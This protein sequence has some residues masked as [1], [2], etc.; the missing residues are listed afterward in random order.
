MTTPNLRF[1][2]TEKAA[3]NVSK[4]LTAAGFGDHQALLPSKF[5]TKKKAAGPA[6][7]EGE[8]PEGQEAGESS[9]A[10]AEEAVKA[11]VAAGMLPKE[12]AST[13]VDKLLED[14]SAVA[15]K[16]PYGRSEEA[17]EILA[18]TGVVHDVAFC[19]PSHTPALFSDSFGMPVLSESKSKT[20]L[21][22]SDWTF[23]NYYFNWPMLRKDSKPTSK[24]IRQKRPWTRSMGFPL[25]LEDPSSSTKLQNPPRPWNSSVGYPLLTDDPTPFSSKMGWAVLSKGK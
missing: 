14:V 15:V 2:T 10:A 18:G 4:K 7:Q 13:C 24:L 16:A 25:L 20:Q 8:A 19:A 1:Y 11:A 12:G 21:L 5:K 23:S 9:R 22:P 6:K 3:L 17:C